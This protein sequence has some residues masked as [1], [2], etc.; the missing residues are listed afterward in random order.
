VVDL[1]ILFSL[2][3]IPMR[4][5]Q[6]YWTISL[7]PPSYRSDSVPIPV[8]PDTAQGGTLL[9]PALWGATF[10]PVSVSSNSQTQAVHANFPFD[11]KDPVN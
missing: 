6:V 11:G 1:E 5:S 7:D 9:P 3:C 4:S 8:S 2:S 10:T